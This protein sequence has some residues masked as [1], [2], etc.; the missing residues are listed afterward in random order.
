MGNFVTRSG[1][2]LQLNGSP[3]RFAGC[4]C[5]WLGLEEQP[6]VQYPTLFQ[7]DDALLVAREMGATV[8]R[9][10]SL[11]ISV[12]N[13]LSVWPSLNTLNSTAFNTIDYAIYRAGQLGLK[14]I[15]PFTDDHHY[16]HGGK[17]TFTDW[18]SVDESVFYTNN[19]VITDFKAYILALLNHVNQYTMLALKNDP[20]ILAWETG[21]EISPLSSWTSTITNYIK[22]IDSNH[23]VISGWKGVNAPDLS[24]ASVDICSDH[25]YPTKISQ[26][27]SGASAASGGGKAYIVGEFDWTHNP[28]NGATAPTFAVDAT[29]AAPSEGVQ[30]GKIVVRGA[31]PDPS[32]VQVQQTGIGLT[33]GHTYAFSFWGKS[34][35]PGAQ[36]TAVLQE[37]HDAYTVYEIQTFALTPSWAQY[38][39]SNYVATATDANTFVGF[40]LGAQAATI[41]LD[42]VSLTDTAAPGTNLLSNASFESGLS[43]WFLNIVTSDDLPAFLSAIEGNA[44]VSGDLF[45]DLRQHDDVQGFV[46]AGGDT[47]AMY[48]PGQ[49]SD[50]RSRAAA[51]R[52]HAYTMAGASPA[53]ASGAMTAAPQVTSAAI[54][55][56]K[57]QLAWRGIA[58][59]GRYVI[60]SAPTAAGPWTTIAA[61]SKTDW[62]VPV[63]DAGRTPYETW[64]RVAAQ[65]VDGSS[66]GPYSDPVV[67]SPAST[68]TFGR[69]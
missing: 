33:L 68:Y 4:N 14:L 60:Q 5:Y 50:A 12:G 62:D 47:Y 20:A 67:A 11:G 23:L 56:G 31:V 53:P 69:T 63:S 39:F 38:S 40:N 43:P 52:T 64:Y 30:S 17:H 8:V 10:H 2:Q 26:M 9:S 46:I 32:T 42:F 7:I 22:S 48:Y 34:D 21:N 24:I 49:S 57:P 16:Y 1:A 54:S 6:A 55:G 25:L 27:T 19:T 59:A 29:T 51:L 15:I 37:N 3:F 41:W 45:W 44:N 28:N 35:T 61:G 58:G 13:P 65:N 66:T 18:R 36:L